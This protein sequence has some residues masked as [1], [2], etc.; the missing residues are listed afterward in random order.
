[1][2]DTSQKRSPPA[3]VRNTE[4]ILA[5]LARVLPARLK[6]GDVVLEIASGSGYHAAAFAAALPQFTWQPSD[7][8]AEAH[9]SIAAYAAEA[10]AENLR[11]PLELHADR[12]PWPVT[13]AAAIVCINMIHISPWAATQ[14][15]FYGAGRCLP[16]GGV[17]VTYGPYSINGDFIAESNLAFDESLKSRNPEWGIRDVKDVAALAAEQGFEHEETIAMPANNHT[18]VFGKAT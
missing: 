5:V 6:D 3:A 8:D 18:L 7:P 13:S 16:P 4:H 9:R 17:V 11:P 12:W 10:S 15:L 2:T 14:G 1:M